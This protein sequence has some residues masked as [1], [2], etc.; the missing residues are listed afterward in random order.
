MWK[1]PSKV[2]LLVGS[3]C[4]SPHLPSYQQ[5]QWQF[6]DDAV[7]DFPKQVDPI[8]SAK[9]THLCIRTQIDRRIS[10]IYEGDYLLELKFW[11]MN[12]DMNEAKT[13]LTQLCHFM[14][15]ATR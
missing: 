15:Y 8:A 3:L 7:A 14:N 1:H 2:D 5:N 9:N 12:S 11:K 4:I 6:E 13:N 10:E